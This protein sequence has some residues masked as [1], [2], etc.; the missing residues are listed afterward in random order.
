MHV[1]FLNTNGNTERMPT[2]HTGISCSF[3][4]KHTSDYILVYDETDL[5]ENVP[6]ISGA[7]VE[8]LVYDGTVQSVKVSA[9]KAGAV[10]LKDSILPPDAYTVSGDVKAKKA[11][12]Y[13]LTITAK[14]GSGYRGSVKVN[15]EV[16]KADQNLT[17]TPKNAKVKQG[18]KRIKAK[19]ALKVS[20]AGLI[21]LVFIFYCFNMVNY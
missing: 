11:G 12:T 8:P 9:V 7:E 17:L 6:P 13:T 2:T 16:K 21:N 4:V 5:N 14:E 19:K 18:T 20:G 3:L 15:W 1:L 10:Q